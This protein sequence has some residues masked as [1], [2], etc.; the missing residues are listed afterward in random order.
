[1]ERKEKFEKIKAELTNPKFKIATDILDTSLDINKLITNVTRPS[2]T[3]QADISE[4]EDILN[5][6]QT[7]KDKLEHF[8][9][10]HEIIILTNPEEILKEELKFGIDNMFDGSPELK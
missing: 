7:L 4:Y 3:K 6:M 10:K 2:S 9:I 5:S 1:M 8:I